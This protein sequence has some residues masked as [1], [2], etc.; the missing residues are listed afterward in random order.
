MK[1]D[2]RVEVVEE[3]AQRGPGGQRGE[4]AGVRRG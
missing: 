2:G 3:E 4:H 1:T